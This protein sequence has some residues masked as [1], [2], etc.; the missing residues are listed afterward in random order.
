[1][2]DYWLTFNSNQNIKLFKSTNYS[3]GFLI[4]KCSFIQNIHSY[5]SLDFKLMIKISK[6]NLTSLMFFENYMSMFFTKK[7]IYDKN[8]KKFPSNLTLYVLIKVQ[9]LKLGL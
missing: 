9:K 4:H 3:N 8:D 5:I 7:R 2:N 6:R 1:M